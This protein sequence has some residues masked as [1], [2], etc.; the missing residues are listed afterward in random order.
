MSV[1]RF[2]FLFVSVFML[3]ANPAQ[4]LHCQTNEI[5]LEEHEAFFAGIP[6]Q[7]QG[8]LLETGLAPVIRAD[9]VEIKNNRLV[10]HFF[11]PDKA[12]W[13]H[14]DSTLLAAGS[15]DLADELFDRALLLSDL[16]AHFIRLKLDGIDALLT[17]EVNNAGHN[18]DVYF[19]D[20]MGE[21]SDNILLPIGHLRFAGTSGPEKTADLPVPQIKSRIETGLTEFFKNRNRSWFQESRLE[22]VANYRADE[23]VLRVTNIKGVVLDLNYFEYLRLTF[24]FSESGGQLNVVYKVDGKYGAGILWAPFISEYR[25][26]SPEFDPALTLFVSE[27][28]KTEIVKLLAP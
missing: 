7:Y 17:I 10:F 24:R 22:V 18:L 27:L 15:R 26:M 25:P 5:V 3:A 14:L 8:W 1:G 16:P 28:L 9:T 2:T 21:I 12:N 13:L 19:A 23:F 4:Y 11:I 6:D 20:K